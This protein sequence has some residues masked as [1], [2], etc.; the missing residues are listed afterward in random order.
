MAVDGWAFTFGTS[1]RGLGG[2]AAYSPSVV[3]MAL[4][5]IIWEI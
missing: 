3:T 5:C 2:A 4:S 1:G